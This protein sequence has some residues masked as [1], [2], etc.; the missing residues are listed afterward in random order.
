M[1]ADDERFVH[2]LEAFSDVVIG[3]SLAQLGAT[4]VIPNHAAELLA[5]PDWLISFAWTF[6]LVCLMWWSHNRLFRTAF[7]P[8]R[9]SLPLNFVLLATIVMLVFLSQVSTHST[10]MA[11]EGLAMRLYFL[12]LAI[13]YLITALLVFVCTPKLRERKDYVRYDQGR[14][15]G[16][17]NGVSGACVA[18]SV[19]A[20]FALGDLAWTFSMMGGSVG[21]GFALGV[22][23]ARRAIPARAS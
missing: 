5:R 20:A 6:A 22:A 1:G 16:I 10:T 8:T 2:R 18:L 23:I 12:V 7:V 19:V 21:V 13:N 3:F 11:D 14:R 15:L 9:L 4:L 17:I